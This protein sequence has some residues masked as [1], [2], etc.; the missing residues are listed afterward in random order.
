MT[1]LDGLP[2]DAE[3]VIIVVH[4]VGDPSVVNI[5]D[6]AEIGKI[7]LG[8]AN[9]KVERETIHNF[10]QPGGERCD[11]QVLIVTSSNYLHVVIPVVWSRLHF[12]AATAASPVYIG[13]I[14]NRIGDAIGFLL[15]A[16]S[17]LVL[18]IFK[19]R[20]RIWSITLG[21]T[22]LF[23]LVLISFVFIGLLELLVQTLNIKE[24][25]EHRGYR[26]LS[27]VVLELISIGVLP[28]IL[29]KFLPL[30][31]LVGDVDHYVGRKKA[32]KEIESDLRKIIMETADRRPNAQII[33]VGHSLGSV[34][35]SQ[36]ASTLT[37]NEIT[38]DRILLLTLGCP[39]RLIS[40]V[41][42]TVKNP[43]DLI[44]D[45]K[46]NTVVHFWANLWRDRDFIG[47]ELGVSNID[48]F[49]EK[50]LGDGVHQGMWGDGRLWH[51]IQVLLTA[52]HTQTLGTIKATWISYMNDTVANEDIFPLTLTLM[53][54]RWC[55]LSGM[56]IV[57]AMVAIGF[58][59]RYYKDQMLVWLFFL[60]FEIITF[61]IFT[62]SHQPREPVDRRYLGNLRLAETKG[63]L[64]V[65]LALFTLFLLMTAIVFQTFVWIRG[66]I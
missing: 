28:F 18:C 66:A 21:L 23:W 51:E 3:T 9:A 10:P 37:L 15:M 32:R 1:A 17:D 40:K 49:S 62:F 53:L 26:V 22:S 14:I 41:F 30:L 31:D 56:I 35:V 55:S 46:R 11:T 58:V 6:E 45:F 59:Q 4:G 36:V 43:N 25:I 65:L 47:R 8:D 52:I 50:S 57:T 24:Y 39:L 7:G 2:I 33:L 38:G 19:A 42:R 54:R 34:L 48:C 29:R 60:L 13:G 64:F 16:W 44:I 5:L 12:R 63:Y 61:G 27:Q 20:K